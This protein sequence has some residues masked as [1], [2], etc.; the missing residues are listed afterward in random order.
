M[1]PAASLHLRAAAA[2]ATFDAFH[3]QTFEWGVRDCVRLAAH[4]LKGLGYKPRLTRGGYYTNELGAL[5]AMKRTGFADLAAAIDDMQLPRIPPAAAAPGDLI[6]FRHPDNGPF[7]VGLGVVVRDST[8]VLGFWATE[9]GVCRVVPP[10][11]DLKDAEYLAWR[12]DP[13]VA[14]KGDNRCR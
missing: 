5:R 8:R 3:G 1:P 14:P 9:D 12:A 10:K 7:G 13:R 4:V 2:Q 11:Y 6:G